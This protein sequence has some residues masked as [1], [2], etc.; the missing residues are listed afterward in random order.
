MATST[1]ACSRDAFVDDVCRH[2]RL[3]QRLALGA[4]PLAAD[5]PLYREHTGLVVELIGHVLADALE[6][7]AA[8]AGGVW[9]FVVDL[10]ARKALG[11]C[12]TLGLLLVFP[13]LRRR[14]CSLDLG[15]QRGQIGVNAFFK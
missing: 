13:A 2:G 6:L 4:D 9:R 10:M 3:Y 15:S 12:L 1:W 8:A 11:Q 7:A 14:L 5:V